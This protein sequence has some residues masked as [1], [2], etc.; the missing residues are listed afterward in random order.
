M[1][2]QFFFLAE[3]EPCGQQKNCDRAC[4][5]SSHITV[6]P[7]SLAGEAIAHTVKAGALSEHSPQLPVPRLAQRGAAPSLKNVFARLMASAE[8]IDKVACF[9][10]WG[11]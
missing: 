10:I 3:R 6:I 7:G 8:S 1:P 4:V 2:Q 11:Q 5:T 9:L